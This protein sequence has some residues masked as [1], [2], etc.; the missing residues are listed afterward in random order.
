MIQ[1]QGGEVNKREPEIL[2]FSPVPDNPGY[3][4][5]FERGLWIDRLGGLP[6]GA[7]KEGG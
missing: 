4:F 5:F 1:G 6:V 7:E 2:Y 3:Y